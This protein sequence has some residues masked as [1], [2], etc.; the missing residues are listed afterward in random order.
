MVEK[1][2]PG[3]H[4]P[5]EASAFTSSDLAF[6]ELWDVFRR[7]KGSANGA[8]G[9]LGQ[10]D[11]VVFMIRRRILEDAVKSLLHASAR[12]RSLSMD[13]KKLLAKR[14]SNAVW[15]GYL[16][17]LAEAEYNAV[18]FRS[19]AMMDFNYLWGVFQGLIRGFEHAMA[20]TPELPVP[21]ARA[22]AEIQSRESEK[23]Q[24]QLGAAGMSAIV[25]PQGEEKLLFA[26]VGGLVLMGY[27]VLKAQRKAIGAE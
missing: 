12:L 6:S 10:V 16:L 23:L 25:G 7:L 14:L 4:G 15:K 27:M 1:P 9:V 8:E 11:P 13:N 26:A 3:D 20:H 19:R 22:L 17:A 18:P 24:E 5:G 21:V 2:A